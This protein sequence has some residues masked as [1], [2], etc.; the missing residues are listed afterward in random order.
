MIDEYIMSDRP[1]YNRA[2]KALRAAHQA[3]FNHPDR[4]I[5]G[6]SYGPFSGTN[7]A[8]EIIAVLEGRY[9]SLR[10]SNKFL[11]TVIKLLRKGNSLTPSI[12]KEIEFMDEPYEDEVDEL[13]SMEVR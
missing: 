10:A 2:L 4:D 3:C 6:M 11:I 13:K 7:Q 5:L 12:I 1:L 9:E 8:L